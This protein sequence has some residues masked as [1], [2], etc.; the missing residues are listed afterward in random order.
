MNNRSAS[1]PGTR[2]IPSETPR[3]RATRAERSADTPY[4]RS[5]LVLTCYAAGLGSWT[6]I[7]ELLERRIHGH[8]PMPHHAAVSRRAGDALA[9][10]LPIGLP[11]CAQMRLPSISM[12][13]G[14]C[15]RRGVAGIG[16]GLS[17]GD[18]NARRD[19]TVNQTTHLERRTSHQ[20]QQAPVLRISFASSRCRYPNV[21][22]L[23]FE[24]DSASVT[25]HGAR[26]ALG[27][28]AVQSR[29]QLRH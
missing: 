27:M 14:S 7:G 2:C 5:R 17:C 9:F 25:Q 10:V 11:C 3:Q 24:S 18:C 4:G 23:P 26:S 29:E 28:T 16:N 1:W 22:C 6:V 8:V 15:S 12:I 20:S 13:G 21:A 19:C